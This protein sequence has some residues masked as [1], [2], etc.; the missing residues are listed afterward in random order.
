MNERPRFV[1]DTNAVVSAL[2]FEHSVPGRAFYGALDAGDI[3]LSEA[4]IRELQDV[5]GRKKFD[6]YLTTEER[7][8]FL[9]K[10]LLKATI[11]EITDE[12]HDCRDPKY[13]KFLAIALS[14][15]ANCIVSGD[16]DLLVLDPWRGISI[17]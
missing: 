3:L 16:D 13:D 14:G 2:L 17:M 8:Q 9:V 11:V 1:F 12:V 5:L 10:L 6:R 15:Q 7:D 4:T